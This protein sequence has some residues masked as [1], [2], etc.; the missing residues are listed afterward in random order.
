LDPSKCEDTVTSVHNRDKTGES[1]NAATVVTARIAC[2]AMVEEPGVVAV[3]RPLTIVLDEQE[4][5]T[6]LCSPAD[7]D[8]LAAGYLFAEGFI[9]DR[10]EIKRLNVDSDRGVVRVSTIGGTG[11]DREVLFRRLITSACGRG[12]A[13]YSAADAVRPARVGSRTAVTP[14]GIRS[15]VDEF[16]ELSCLFESTGGVHSAALADAHHILLRNDD[17]GRHNAIDKV[18]GECIMKGMT[19]EGRVIISSGRVPSEMVLKAARGR[20]P[21]LVS[22]GATTDLGVRLADDLGITLVGFVRGKTMTVYS[23]RWRVSG[24]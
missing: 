19:T 21:I 23:N 11:Q 20:V 2:D 4:L 16:N 13:F 1:S 9:E 15:L 24:D 8:Y 5:V 3:E 17:L 22:L 14:S 10:K 7:M 6:L 18:F 12:A